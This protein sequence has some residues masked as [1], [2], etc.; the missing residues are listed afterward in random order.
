MIRFYYNNLLNDAAIQTS[1]ENAQFPKS[2]V[3]DERRSKVFRSTTNTDTMT[4]DF[5]VN[6]AIDSFF[7]VDNPQDGFGINTL[8]LSAS[9]VPTFTPDLLSAASV[10]LDNKFGQ[11][12]LSFNEISARYFRLSATSTLGYC[13]LSNFFVGKEFR[14]KDDKSINFGWTYEESQ[15]VNQSVNKIG[16][17]FSDLIGS[18]RKF[19]CS[20]TNLDKDHI[21]E[22]NEMIDYVG[23]HR[24]FWINIGCP[25]MNNELP[26]FRGMVYLDSIPRFTNTFFNR[27]QTSLTMSEAR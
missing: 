22:L 16:Q 13:E 10:S 18:Q 19:T 12:F 9:S 24:P 23:T 21:E 17:R 8:S 5:G 26:R 20:F 7:I 3:R 11:G 14:L 4:L 25:S 1:T 15:I 27:Y 2:N 6:E